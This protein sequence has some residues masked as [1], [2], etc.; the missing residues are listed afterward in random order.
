MPNRSTDGVCLVGPL[1]PPYGGV[2]E[3]IYRLVSATPQFIS[4]IID[5]YPTTVRKL[6]PETSAAS[7]SV[8]PLS[9][10]FKPVWFLQQLG[11]T[12]CSVFHFHF[13]LPRALL[14]LTFARKRAEKT[15]IL[16]LHNGDLGIGAHYGNYLLKKLI[17]AQVM[18]FDRIVCL[19][20]AHE[21]F[22]LQIGVPQSRLIRLPSYL[23]PPRRC[24]SP[25]VPSFYELRQRNAVV[26]LTSGYPEKFYNFD[27]LVDYADS[28]KLVHGAGVGFAIAVYG[29]G[30]W[31]WINT[32]KV[33][34][35]QRG[36]EVIFLENLDRDAFASVIQN[37]DIYV[38]PT[39]MDSYGIAVADA[40]NC[41]AIAIASDICERY[42]GCKIFPTGDVNAF[43]KQLD[44]SIA[45]VQL[46]AGHKRESVNH[47]ASG[48][49]IVG[50]CN[51]YSEAKT[52][53]H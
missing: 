53:A 11:R 52:L 36:L 7:V 26:V 4:E 29:N 12:K 18:R 50:Y 2:S 47:P 8:A 32:L 15:W 37:T 25:L 13:S 5:L 3:H 1:P 23:P 6:R 51:L 42:E 39:L 35:S 28:H 24:D 9:R 46:N 27:Q 31:S 43:F 14:L 45:E 33:I 49:E 17:H 21:Q 34:A 19:S 48:G 38:R 30:D 10:W 44:Y 22:C 20:S 41:G 16:T 40:I